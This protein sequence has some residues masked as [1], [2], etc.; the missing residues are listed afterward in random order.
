MQFVFKISYGWQMKD[1]MISFRKL[2]QCWKQ[3]GAI[4]IFIALNMRLQWKL[5]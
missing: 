5:Y 4:E 1:R 3:F 2:S